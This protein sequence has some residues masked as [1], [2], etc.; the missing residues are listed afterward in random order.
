MLLLWPV[1]VLTTETAN[2]Y[3]FL[4]NNFLITKTKQDKF[5]A[6]YI[7]SMFYSVYVIKQATEPQPILPLIHY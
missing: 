7:I 5:D 3:W 6:A 1:R 2:N 4:K